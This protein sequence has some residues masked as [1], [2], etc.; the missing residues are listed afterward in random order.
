MMQTAKKV[1]L[2]SVLSVWISSTLA[3]KPKLIPV[4]NGVFST[5]QWYFEGT[6][7]ALGGNVYFNFVPALQY[8]DKFTLIPSIETNYRGT[9]SAE[10]LAG[11]NTLF[12]DTWENAL[13]VKGVHTLNERW[14]VKERVAG[15]TKWFRETTDE[16]WTNGLYDYNSVTVGAEVERKWGKVV[17][18]S[19][20]YDFSLLTFPNYSSLESTQSGDNAREFSGSNVLDSQVHLLSMHYKTPLLWGV[21]SSMGLFYNPHPTLNICLRFF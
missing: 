19:L 21:R 17:A 2:F 18:L 10:E 11:G 16:T 12:Q 8:S 13:S 5:G 3:A 20:G 7:S 4:A 14:S 1:F 15:R 9:R 6:K